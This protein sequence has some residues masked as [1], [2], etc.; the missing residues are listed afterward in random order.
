MLMMQT[1][2]KSYY[3][4]GVST[5]KSHF[6]QNAFIKQGYWVENHQGPYS[7]HSKGKK[8]AGVYSTLYQQTIFLL[9]PCYSHFISL[10]FNTDRTHNSGDNGVC[11]NIAFFFLSPFLFHFHPLISAFAFEYLRA[12]FCLSIGIGVQHDGWE[13]TFSWVMFNTKIRYLYNG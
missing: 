13:G 11:F 10:I 5:T 1:R 3:Q 2:K 7:S 6:Q 8:R 4:Q 9:C 12:T